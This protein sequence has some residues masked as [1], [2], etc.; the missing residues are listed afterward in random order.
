VDLAVLPGVQEPDGTI[1]FAAHIV[2]N[3]GVN[4]QGIR[5]A[6]TDPNGTTTS[7][8]YT[9]TNG[10]LRYTYQNPTNIMGTYHYTLI[11]P[12]V[13]G[14]T[15]TVNGSFTYQNDALGII[16]SIPPSIRSGDVITIK[17]DQKISP[18]D[19]RV[20]YRVNN[21]PQL[22]VSRKDAA[23]KDKYDT[24]PEFQGWTSDTVQYARVYAEAVHYF[25][26]N[27]ERFSN[28][29]EDPTNYTFTTAND[30]NIG[31]KTPLVEWNITLYLL[32]KS[33]LPN[34]VNYQVPYAY[35]QAA[36]PGFEVVAA[37]IAIIIAVVLVKRKKSN[38]K[39]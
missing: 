12:D 22:N 21:G 32:R 24:S 8:Q 25:A 33:Q 30:P 36:T 2:D 34:T 16:S 28:T 17:A 19:F 15:T 20:Y 11:A 18:Q 31:T 6:I 14:H 9:F 3:V 39:T 4:A 5:L 35:G 23:S 37:L 13:N 38:R 10:I 29:V 26:N 1:F 7:S 27:P